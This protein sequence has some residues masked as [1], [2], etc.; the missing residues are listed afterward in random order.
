[1]AGVQCLQLTLL[2]G[3]KRFSSRHGVRLLDLIFPFFS[4]QFRH[5]Q[6]EYRARCRLILHNTSTAFPAVSLLRCAKQDATRPCIVRWKCTLRLSARDRLSNE[7]PNVHNH[8]L[9]ADSSRGLRAS[10]INVRS[11]LTLPIAMA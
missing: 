2:S 4:V 9:S 10:T 7:V 5:H 11:L 3:V 6:V 1:M 8:I